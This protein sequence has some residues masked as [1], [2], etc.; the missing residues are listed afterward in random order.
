MVFQPTTV[1]IYIQ[2]ALANKE[3]LQAIDLQQAIEQRLGKL[4]S[5]SAFE[6]QLEELVR[7]GKVLRRTT[8]VY[9]LHQ[10]V[11]A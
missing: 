10:E 4:C 6:E 9:I 2:N 3:A 11:I 5:Q 7:E 8:T 1:Q